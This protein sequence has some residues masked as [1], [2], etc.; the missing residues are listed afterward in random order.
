MGDAVLSHGIT[1]ASREHSPGAQPA[2]DNGATL[3]S[4]HAG[5]AKLARVADETLVADIGGIN[6][7]AFNPDRRWALR[8]LGA[9][10]LGACVGLPR[11][12]RAATTS[13][14]LRFRVLCKGSPIGQHT[15]TFRQ[16]GE[17]LTVTT[18]IDITVKVMMFTTYYLKHDAVEIL[19]AGRLLAVTSATDDNGTRL[20]VTGNAVA[21]GFRII[22]EAGPFLAP[23][24]LLTTNMLW[25]TRTLSEDR[26]IDVQYGGVVGLA[27]KRRGQAPVDTPKG[28]VLANS[29]HLITPHYAGTLFHD[30]KGLWVKGLIEAKG[31]IIE[32]ALAS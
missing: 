29:H 4:A 30:E 13:T 1:H 5:T 14:N 12:A 23:G 15:I 7:P 8:L 11:Q 25:D 16:D 27:V 31:E 22:G 18:H 24:K 9:A 32:Y 17:R 26:L 19:Q 10:A 20:Q 3:S 2:I 21:D 6:E 28:K